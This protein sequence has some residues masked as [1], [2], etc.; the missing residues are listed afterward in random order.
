MSDGSHEA[1]IRNPGRYLATAGTP[2]SRSIV[3]NS[4]RVYPRR[5]DTT[6]SCRVVPPMPRGNEASHPPAIATRERRRPASTPAPLPPRPRVPEERLERL[7]HRPRPAEQR[8]E[9]SDVPQLIADGARVCAPVVQQ[10]PAD[11]PLER[12]A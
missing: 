4:A 6:A 3:L 2:A 7:D 1:T 8:V 11:H 10:L 12:L 9:S 5:N